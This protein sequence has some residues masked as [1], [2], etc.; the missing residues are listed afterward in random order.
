MAPTVNCPKKILE[1]FFNILHDY[2]IS[3]YFTRLGLQKDPKI[4]NGPVRVAE[5]EPAG[6]KTFGR[7]RS[8]SWY[9]EVSAPAPAPGSGS[10]AN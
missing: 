10:R 2:L 7:S 3:F 9:T 8:W 6:A 4:N 5:P 1:I